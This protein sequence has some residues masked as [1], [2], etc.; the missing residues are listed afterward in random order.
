MNIDLNSI[1]KKLE[2]LR[3]KKGSDVN[4]LNLKEGDNQI[5]VIAHPDRP[6]YVET[7]YHYIVDA[8]NERKSIVCRK[9]SLGEDSD[10][11][12]CDLVSKL[13]KGDTTEREL[14][15]SIARRYR[16]FLNVI[17]RADG[18][19]KVFGTGIT[20]FEQILS[21]IADSDWGDMTDPKN[22]YDIVIRKSGSGF[23]TEYSVRAKPKR[24]PYGVDIDWE[25]VTDLESIVKV[26]TYKEQI[27]Q[28]YGQT[29]EELE[30][31][32]E[33]EE[34][35]SK[36]Q[37]LKP[38]PKVASTTHEQ[39]EEDNEELQ[40]QK[41]KIVKPTSKVEPEDEEA[42]LDAEIQKALQKFKTAKGVK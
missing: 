14:A 27:A 12:V 10:C 9:L 39:D 24:T 37:P 13:R 38:T 3:K 4:W 21:L 36:P 20:V 8:D 19:I 7:G 18:Q 40:I 15:K 33:V 42:D 28:Y 11:F 16:V 6:W 29:E 5:R 34:P 22:G 17:D 30:Q 1:K 41:P 26:P 25:S 35:K 23:N 31:N 2:E 32:E